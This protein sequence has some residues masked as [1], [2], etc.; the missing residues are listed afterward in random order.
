MGIGGGHDLVKGGREAGDRWVAQFTADCYHQACD[1]W[2]DA[3]DL[4]GAA[5]D[6]TLIYEMAEE[7]ANSHAWPRWNPGSEFLAVRDTSARKR[8]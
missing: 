2:N 1:R 3:W 5:Q 7:L 6:A 8:K 4:R